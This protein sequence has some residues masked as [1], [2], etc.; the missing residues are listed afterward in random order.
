MEKAR[1]AAEKIKLIGA[2]EA[3]A[4]ENVG[5]AE[6][7]AMRLKASA[8]KQYGDAAVLA[9]VLEALPKVKGKHFSHS[10]E[11]GLSLTTD[12]VFV[13]VFIVRFRLKW[14]LP[15]PRRK[16]SSC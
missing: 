1:A 12:C 8:Y 13:S 5:R 16:K 2:A 10:R 15:Y 9:L 4:I 7:E 14:P 6:A 11:N 3:T